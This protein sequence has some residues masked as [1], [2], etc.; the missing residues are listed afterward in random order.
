MRQSG[1]VKDNLGQ[2][3][4]LAKSFRDRILASLNDLDGFESMKNERLLTIHAWNPQMAALFYANEHMVVTY[5]MTPDAA[6]Q[7]AGLQEVDVDPY[8]MEGFL[9][10]AKELGAQI[11]QPKLFVYVDKDGH[12]TAAT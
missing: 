7:L 9:P 5:K 8:D 2:D 3:N 1:L 4:A 6:W 12:D 11:M 10:Q